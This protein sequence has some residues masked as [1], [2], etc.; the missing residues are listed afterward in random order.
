[1]VLENISREFAADRLMGHTDR[2]AAKVRD[3]RLW[4]LDWCGEV[5]PT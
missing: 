2:V 1:L 5:L 3:G 4:C